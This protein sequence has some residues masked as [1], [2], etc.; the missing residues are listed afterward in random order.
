[1]T[2]YGNKIYKA[3]KAKEVAW[4]KSLLALCGA[5]K[6]FIS[7]NCRE[8]ITWTGKEDASGAAALFASMTS[9]E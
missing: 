4:Y 7:N 8:V 1:M 2:F 5:L 6:Q 3:D 9:P